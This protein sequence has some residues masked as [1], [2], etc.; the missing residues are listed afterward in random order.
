MKLVSKIRSFW[1]NSAQ[2]WPKAG[3]LCIAFLACLCS[4]SLAD[5]STNGQST[6]ISSSVLQEMLA[7][8]FAA[9]ASTDGGDLFASYVVSEFNG[10][11]DILLIKTDAAGKILWQK[12]YGRA[13]DEEANAIRPTSD[14]GYILVGSTTSFTGNS[15]DIYLL[16]LDASGAVQWER[17][18]GGRTAITLNANNTVTSST[19]TTN[20]IDNGYSVSTLNSS[21]GLSKDYY[22]TYVLVP[23]QSSADETTA[24]T[25]FAEDVGYDVVASSDGGYVLTGYTQPN[26][27]SADIVLLKVDSGGVMQWARTFGGGADDRP[28]SLQEC[29]DKGFIIAGSTTSVGIGSRARAIGDAADRTDKDAYLIKTD[30]NGY[31]QWQKT[32]GG[33]NDDEANCVIQNNQGYVIAGYTV[34]DSKN[35]TPSLMLM[36]TDSSGNGI[37]QTKNYSASAYYIP[38]GILNL[39]SGD[40]IIAGN[41]IKFGSTKAMM[42]E[43]NQ[44]GI[45]LWERDW[46][47]KGNALIYGL[48][49]GKN[50]KIVSYGTLTT[51]DSQSTDK[52]Q[53][54]PLIL[55]YNTTGQLLTETIIT[56]SNLEAG[57]TISTDQTVN[58]TMP[59]SPI[60]KGHRGSGSSSN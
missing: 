48:L 50:G 42:R 60:P 10:S 53:V 14:G 40:T 25:D 3:L 31:L 11:K 45:C 23:N 41:T 35:P 46:Q 52:Q 56:G 20:T 51:A 22:D 1:V 59:E 29:G 18:Y 7:P 27:G 28:S 21:K 49:A 24:D 39:T 9:C 5:T 44:N 19:T 55:E 36:Q 8:G 17:N 13:G 43:Y 57:G 33:S 54:N 2:N 12:Q 32:F 58:G 30:S 47:G 4:P 37:W 15:L 38:R 16:K 26:G 34:Q 6:I